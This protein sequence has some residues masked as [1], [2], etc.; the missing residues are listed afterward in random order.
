MGRWMK[1]GRMT[2][3]ARPDSAAAPLRSAGDSAGA[4]QLLY[5]YLSDRFANRVVLTF[6]EIEDLLGFSLPERARLQ[7]EWW[8]NGPSIAGRSTQSDSWTLASRTATVNMSAQS[9]VFERETAADP[10]RRR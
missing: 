6:A 4:Y 3:I 7:L 1:R 5:K 10:P 8:G 2:G 9:V